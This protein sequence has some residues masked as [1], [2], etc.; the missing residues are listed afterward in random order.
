MNPAILALILGLL[1]TTALTIYWPNPLDRNPSPDLRELSVHR[2][3]RAW[4]VVAIDRRVRS[5]QTRRS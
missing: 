5:A 2:R 1:T 4:R 3:R